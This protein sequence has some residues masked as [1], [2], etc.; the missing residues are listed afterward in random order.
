M[1]VFVVVLVILVTMR[2]K[3]PLLFQGS[4]FDKRV[5]VLP[6]SYWSVLAMMVA[7]I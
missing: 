2:K 6:V 3:S 4:E 5:L 1:F 7:V